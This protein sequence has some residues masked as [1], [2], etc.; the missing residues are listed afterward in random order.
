MG[1]ADTAANIRALLATNGNVNSAI[2]RL[3]M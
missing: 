1:F 3:L 2:E